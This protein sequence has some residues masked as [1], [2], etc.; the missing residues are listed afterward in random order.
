LK[1]CDRNLLLLLLVLGEVIAE[2]KVV[3]AAIILVFP[4]GVIQIVQL[5]PV[6]LAASYAL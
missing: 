6:L 1:K 2:S 5:I 4:N 3:F